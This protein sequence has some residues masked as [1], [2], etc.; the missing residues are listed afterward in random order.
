MELMRSATGM[1]HVFVNGSSRC[2][3]LVGKFGELISGAASDI[4]CKRC[5]SLYEEYD[6]KVP[7]PTPT[8]LAHRAPLARVEQE[9]VLMPNPG[10]LWMATRGKALWSL[11][12]VVAVCGIALWVIGSM[13]N[14]SGGT[15][16]GV[17]TNVDFG[18]HV[19]LDCADFATHDEAQAYY[20]AH[21]ADIDGLDGYD[22]DGVAC[23]SLP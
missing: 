7:A 11:V 4:T 15:D 10:A 17:D 2:G 20:D 19:D 16:P 8:A 13:I 1:V 18:G 14:D 6:S 12:K 21:P 3:V 23:E 5:I 22:N 9:P